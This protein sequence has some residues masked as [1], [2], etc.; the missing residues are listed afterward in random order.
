MTNIVVLCHERYRLT[1]QCLESI[2][3][4]TKEG[5]YTLTLVD[6]DSQDFRVRNFLR[7]QAIYHPKDTTLINVVGSK[8]CLGAL[9]NLGIRHSELT[10]VRG[11][12]LCVLD[13][14]VCVFEGWLDRL[15]KL[16]YCGDEYKPSLGPFIIGGTRH[17]FHHVNSGS[18]TEILSTDAVAGYC[19]FMNWK[20]WDKCGPYD[21][22]ALGIG[23]SEDF[24]I[25]Q[26]VIK[27]TFGL[28]GYIDPPVLAH[29]GITNSHGELI[30]GHELVERVPGV[31]Y[32]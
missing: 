4:N 6:D 16:E 20:A 18:G 13:H 32:L 23:Q 27:F 25:C 8:H 28:V 5:T 11:E 24:S 9:K 31:L 22:N 30:A 2:R 10:F 17:P 15:N 26:R 29:T 3:R 1:V 14:D 7:D 21:A 19:H 12:W